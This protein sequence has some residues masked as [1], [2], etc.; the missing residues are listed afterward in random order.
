MATISHAIQQGSSCLQI[1]LLAV[2][3]AVQKIKGATIM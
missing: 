2:A 1:S 3:Y